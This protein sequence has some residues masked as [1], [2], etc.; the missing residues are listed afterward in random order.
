MSNIIQLKHSDTAGEKPSSLVS[1]EIGVNTADKKIFIT[2]D[3]AVTAGSMFKAGE[4]AIKPTSTNDTTNVGYY[5]IM[6]ADEVV[7]APAVP[8]FYKDDWFVSNG[9]A[10]VLI[11]MS[12]K[13][14]SDVVGGYAPLDA[15]KKIPAKYISVEG[16]MV[17]KG[18]WSADTDG[19]S[20]PHGTP[21]LSDP[22]NFGDGWYYIVS[23]D[24]SADLDSITDW[25]V[26]DWAVYTDSTDTWEKIDNTQ[27]SVTATQVAFTPAG[28]IAA[29]D[30][31]AAIEELD[32]EKQAS[33]GIGGD[34][35]VL[36]MD[37]INIIWDTQ[38]DEDVS[39]SAVTSAGNVHDAL[40]N[41]DQ[42]AHAYSKTTAGAP[43]TSLGNDGDLCSVTDNSDVTNSVI[44]QKVNGA[45]ETITAGPGADTFLNLQ[46][47][48]PSTYTGQAGKFV[49]VNTTTTPD[50]DGL[51]FTDTIDGGTFS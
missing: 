46:D 28:D 16:G 26:G 23:E 51:E 49:I 45:W 44:Y 42:R 12:P 43:A 33:L 21:D 17:Y 3:G 9:T 41:L 1:G 35:K 47:V 18:T 14:M 13:H 27:E 8:S 7:T 4:M 31:Q 32:T 48:D 6:T 2:V 38:V 5:Y 37:G 11:K 40:I 22:A 15:N 19:G 20:K 29:T 10:W 36:K 50:G 30:V 25:K 34:K 39:S 24:G